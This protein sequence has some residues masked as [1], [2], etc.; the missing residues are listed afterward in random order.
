MYMLIALYFSSKFNTKLEAANA[1]ENVN[2]QDF[3][4]IFEFK[5]EVEF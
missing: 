5:T 3:K 1:L 2:E 4:R